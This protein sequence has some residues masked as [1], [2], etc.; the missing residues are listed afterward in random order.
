M[1]FSTFMVNKDECN[2]IRSSSDTRGGFRGT[3]PAP[4]PFGRRTKFVFGRDSAPDPAGGA[5]I[6]PQILTYLLEPK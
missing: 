5:Y 2:D 3:E 4:A 1:F 6:A